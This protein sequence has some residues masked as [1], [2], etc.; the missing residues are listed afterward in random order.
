MKK[1]LFLSVAALILSALFMPVSVVAMAALVPFGMNPDDAE[2]LASAFSSFEGESLYTG[3]GD[4]Y[5]DFGG[6]NGSFADL[7]NA[8]R[9]FVVN[10]KNDLT[11]TENVILLPGYTWF[12]SASGNNWLKEGVI[13]TVDNQTLSASGSP[14]TITEFLAF[15]MRNPTTLH[16]MRF[17]SSNATQVSQQMILKE[18]SPFKD[19]QS[20]VIDLGAYVNEN[21]YK[22]KMV[23]V[24]LHNVVISSDVELSIPIMANSTCTITFFCGA[25]ANASVT[26]K[27]KQEKAVSTINH[28]GLG[29]VRRLHSSIRIAKQNGFKALRS[30]E[31]E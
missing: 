7:V 20:R 19:L 14:K 29:N 12:S 9:I 22:D 16:A 1:Y 17:S 26:L 8:E 18:L 3:Y 15:I 23:T 21:T 24:P 25:V 6:P 10:I 27:R 4:D 13:K 5:V 28:I 2:E 11:T 30:F 31:G